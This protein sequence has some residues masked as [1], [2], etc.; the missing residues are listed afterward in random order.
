MAARLAAIL[1]VLHPAHGSRGSNTADDSHHWKPP[2]ADHA[3][4]TKAAL[5]PVTNRTGSRLPTEVTSVQYRSMYTRMT[6]QER[7]AWRCDGRPP[8]G[9]PILDAEKLNCTSDF[10]TI[11]LSSQ[12]SDRTLF[13]C[14]TIHGFGNVA[15]G[16]S[17]ALGIAAALG[18]RLLLMSCDDASS[19]F[20]AA[21]RRV[22]PAYRNLAPVNESQPPFVDWPDR[23]LIYN[24]WPPFSQVMKREAPPFSQA[25]G[26]A[27]IGPIFRR[28]HALKDAPHVGLRL[29]KPL[30]HSRGHPWTDG[31][32]R[33]Y[34]LLCGGRMRQSPSQ[35]FDACVRH[36]VFSQADLGELPYT[37]KI[38]TQGRSGNKQLVGLHIRTGDCYES[39]M[40]LVPN[41]SASKYSCT[42]SKRDKRVPDGHSWDKFFECLG[43]AA[44]KV[45]GTSRLSFFVATDW[46]PAVELAE[47]HLPHVMSVAGLGPAS[48]IGFDHSSATLMRLLT[49]FTILAHADLQV[50]GSSSLGRMAAEASGLPYIRYTFSR[51]N[52]K[53]PKVTYPGLPQLALVGKAGARAG[54]L[55]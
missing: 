21:L 26:D 23:K 8:L 2:H 27:D 48:H 52:A 14:V 40:P 24:S 42:G 7:T 20:H 31:F 13:Y 47:A 37:R 11:P 16:V 41:N 51:D 9:V 25:Q 54:K 5:T 12:L 19:S 22:F 4:K 38:L 30:L 18:R 53:C 1:L 29:S 33:N 44:R 36:L 35:S 43:K 3:K 32:P 50:V 28:L 15:E 55:P 39:S 17:T 10:P 34:A 49:D 6:L 45:M 46:P